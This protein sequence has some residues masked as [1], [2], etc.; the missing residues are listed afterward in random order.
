VGKR[1]KGFLAGKD[2]TFYSSIT[3][4]TLNLEISFFILNGDIIYSFHSNL[5]L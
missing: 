1:P 5:L 4:S 2:V 3:K